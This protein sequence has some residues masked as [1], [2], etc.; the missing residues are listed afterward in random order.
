M[1]RAGHLPGAKLHS[2]PLGPRRLIKPASRLEVA[3]ITSRGLRSPRQE[4]KDSSKYF[5]ERS[6]PSR[7][8]ALHD[9]EASPLAAAG[10]ALSASHESVIGPYRKQV[11]VSGGASLGSPERCRITSGW[12]TIL[13]P[14]S[15]NRA[16]IE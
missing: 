14:A 2:R 5:S 6:A 11:S 3:P 16:Y 13:D 15:L 7:N 1:A 8:L 10:G 9:A 12:P 4:G